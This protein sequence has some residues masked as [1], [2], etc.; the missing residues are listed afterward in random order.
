[1]TGYAYK[2]SSKENIT[3]SVEIKSY[4]SRFLDLSIYMAPWLSPLESWIREYLSSRFARGK[5]E[6]GIRVKEEGAAVSFSVNK[7]AAL[8]YKKAIGALAKT[9]GTNEEPGL[10][11]ILGLEGVFEVETERDPERYRPYIEP[12]LVSAAD[13]AEA[14][15]EREGAHTKENIITHVSVLEE[16]VKEISSYVPEMEAYIKENL[17]VRF[18]EL[19]GNGVD[20]SRI[21]AETAVLLMKYTISEELSRL[22]S[23]LSEFRLEMT[24]DASPGKKLDFLSQEINREINT[25]GSKTPMLE[26]SRLVVDMKNALENIREQLRNVE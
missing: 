18:K 10:G 7:N 11:L 8:E 16:S 15:R 19:L 21:L 17:R 6:V 1:M 20:E 23:H 14:E 25:I 4:N 3:V 24:K 26:V 22:D 13:Q 9:L 2:I 5:V 12:V